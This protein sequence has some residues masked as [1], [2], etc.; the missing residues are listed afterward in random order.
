MEDGN[1]N[2][3]G[4]K[5]KLNF[6]E[7]FSFFFREDFSECLERYSV[8]LTLPVLGTFLFHHILYTYSVLGLLLGSGD[9]KI[10]K[11]ITTWGTPHWG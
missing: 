4:L 1:S 3:H 6:R 11:R 10:Y 9:I 8:S 7:D 5:S 2:I